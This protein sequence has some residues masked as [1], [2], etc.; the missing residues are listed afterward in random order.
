LLCHFMCYTAPHALNVFYHLST[1]LEYKVAQQR[2][3]QLLLLDSFD[4]AS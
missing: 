3:T 2:L 4:S 1:G